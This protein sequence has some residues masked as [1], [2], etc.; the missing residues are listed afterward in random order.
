MGITITEYA[1]INQLQVCIDYYYNDHYMVNG[2]AV[3]MLYPSVA[4]LG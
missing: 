4:H 3:Y 2:H 1:K